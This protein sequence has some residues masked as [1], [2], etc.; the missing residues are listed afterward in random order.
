[1]VGGG[2]V[3]L[4]LL[5]GFIATV[6]TMVEVSFSKSTPYTQSLAQARAN[7]QVIEKF[8][9]PIEPGWFASGSIQTNGSSGTADL[10]IPIS[11]PKAKGAIYVAAKKSAGKW[12]FETLEVEVQGGPNRINLLSVPAPGSCN[13]KT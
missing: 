10:S 13:C 12:S 11:G 4:I 7:P 5:A 1:M 9:H 3:L 8:G 6:L 2:L